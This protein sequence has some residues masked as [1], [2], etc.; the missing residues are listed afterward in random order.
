MIQDARRN[1]TGPFG[2]SSVALL[3]GGMLAFAGSACALRENTHT[4]GSVT[5][6]SAGA[7]VSTKADGAASDA[8]ASVP[9][10]AQSPS[11]GSESDGGGGSDG[12]LADGSASGDGG[13]GYPAD[14]STDAGENEF[15]PPEAGASAGPPPSVITFDTLPD[16][17]ALGGSERITNQY[18]GVV[19]SSASCGGP[20]TYSDGE[21]TSPPNFLVGSPLVNNIGISPIAMDLASP[22]A[23]VGTVLIGVGDSTVTA[24]AYDATQSV[25][26]T[27]SVT[28]PGT[29]NGMNAH[30]PITL[31]GPGIVRVVYEITK[32]W[33]PPDGLGDG[34]GI[35][36]VTF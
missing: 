34:F 10:G 4:A 12:A 28:H 21:E 13:G 18:P 22:V 30:D 27:V 15:C 7:E 1:R 24:T 17:T 14:A 33:P 23:K 26:A 36:D 8:A 9:D 35:D 3:V 2:L 20:I 32:R 19:F 25:V 6:G 29:T 11:N 5:D 16:G 31:A